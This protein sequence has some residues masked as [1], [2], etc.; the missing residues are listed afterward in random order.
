[1]RP[2]F[3]PLYRQVILSD[4]IQLW[5]GT[6]FVRGC[7]RARKG[8]S[9]DCVS[10]VEA[11]LVECEAIRPIEWPNYVNHGG[12]AQMFDLLIQTIEQI[13]NMRRVEFHVEL[14]ELLPGD[15][16]V[17]SFKGDY[18]HLAIFGGDKTLWHMRPN[19]LSTANIF[20]RMAVKDL[21]AIYR[22]YEQ[23]TN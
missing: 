7:G 14:P 10:F 11:V 6:R 12:G 2:F 23:P 13:P 3:Q 19:G 16:F 8:V 17:R 22:V 4:V 21:R 18:H 5:H 15:L 1:M 20:D 9:A